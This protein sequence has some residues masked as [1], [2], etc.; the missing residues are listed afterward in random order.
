MRVRMS[1]CARVCV[2]VCVYSALCIY[3]YICVCFMCARERMREGERLLH[4]EMRWGEVAVCAT[5]NDATKDLGRG[6]ETGRLGARGIVSV[7][8]AMTSV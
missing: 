1:V 7:D 8:E 5:V 4:G 6:E 3:V 2:R